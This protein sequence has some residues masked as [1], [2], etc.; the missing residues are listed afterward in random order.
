MVRRLCGST[1]RRRTGHPAQSHPC[2]VVTP[3]EMKMAPMD[4]AASSVWRRRM[5]P[6]RYTEVATTSSGV[7]LQQTKTALMDVA[8]SSV[9]R[10]QVAPPRYTEVAQWV[11]GY[12]VRR[13][14]LNRA[15]GARGHSL[16]QKEG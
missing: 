2:H 1:H 15:T 5:A 6:R 3:P 12:I 10:R 4:V 14:F 16:P 7:L 13:H 9:W 8:A 11:P